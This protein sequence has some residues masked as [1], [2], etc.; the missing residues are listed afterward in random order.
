MA[1]NFLKN[2]LPYLKGKKEKAK[3]AIKFQ[4]GIERRRNKKGHILQVSK[5]ENQRREEIWLKLNLHRK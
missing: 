5:R 4:E 1:M 3:L 2:I